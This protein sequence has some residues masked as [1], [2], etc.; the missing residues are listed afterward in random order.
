VLRTPAIYALLEYLDSVCNCDELRVT[1]Q[2]MWAGSSVS[3]ACSSTGA[4]KKFYGACRASVY[5]G[6]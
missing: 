1:R 5:W 2:A 4:I 6:L 3:P